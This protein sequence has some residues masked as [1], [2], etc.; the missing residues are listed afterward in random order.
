MTNQDILLH[1]SLIEGI[2]PATVKKISDKVGKDLHLHDLYSLTSS[3]L[4]Y[5]FD[6]SESAAHKIVQGLVDKK[7]LETELDLIKKHS[8]G[9]VDLTSEL[10]PALL[11]QIYAPPIVLYYQGAPLNDEEHCLAVIGSRK[12]HSYAERII[13]QFIPEL[14][15]HGFTIVSGGALGADSMAHSATVHARGKTVAVLGSGLLKP[16]PLSN[17]RLFE[18]IVASGGT[19]VSPFSLQT[20]ALPG[21]FPARNR[22]I[23]GLSHGCLVVQAAAQSGARITANFALDQGR[24]VFAIP[25]PIDDELS[26]GCHDLI[27]QGATLVSSAQDICNEF[28]QT[29]PSRK[30]VKASRQ[31]A[32]VFVPAQQVKSFTQKSFIESV[33]VKT[34][35]EIVH[36]SS[37]EGTIVALCKKVASFDE[38]AAATNLDSTELHGLLFDLQLKGAIKQNFAGM[39]ETFN[40]R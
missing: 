7:I 32:P 28:K 11:K 6:L 37:P 19:L 25:G 18:A 22:I 10:Y 12:A 1:L 13:G 21:N 14:V 29:A 2:G 31:D 26:G 8:I 36:D 4:I 17:K 40:S 5:R 39:W 34:S 23:S 38:I 35:S 33:A 9:V 16:Y 27:R 30:T 15:A 24:E 20:A 3:D